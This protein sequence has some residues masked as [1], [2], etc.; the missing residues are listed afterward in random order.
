MSFKRMLRPSNRRLRILVGLLLAALFAVQ[1]TRSEAFRE[2]TGVVVIDGQAF[3]KNSQ[4][5]MSKLERL[6]KTDQ[7]ALLEYCLENY[8]QK[9]NDYTCQ[10]AKQEVIK[11]QTRPQ[12]VMDVKFMGQPFSVTM[13]WTQNP[14]IGDKLIYVEGKYN[15][16]MLVRPA[17][18]LLRK[19]AGTVTRR[20]DDQ[21]AMNNT[22]RPVNMFGFERNLM[23][24]LTIYRQAQK[25][26]DLKQEFAGYAK[27]NDR[28]ALT[29]VRYLPDKPEYASAASKTLI[30]IDAEYLVPIRIEGYDWSDKQTSLYEF[31]DVKFN[32]GLSDESFLPENN[33]MKPP[34]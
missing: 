29:L 7:I 20:P 32:L 24:L 28:P 13:T 3:G 2:S 1:C 21:D 19:I 26:G 12:Q 16:E 6:A 33:D 15:N 23:S 30:F 8:R 9:Y 4:S 14:P 31:R 17:N 34:K 10:F 25:N 11:G 5:T 22:L 27:V 18:G